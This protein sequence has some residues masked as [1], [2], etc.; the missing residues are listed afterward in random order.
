MGML[1]FLLAS[2]VVIG[3]APG[4][5]GMGVPTSCYGLHF[6]NPYYAV[7]VFFVISGFYMATVLSE[8]YH[9]ARNGTAL[10]Y[11][12]RLTRLLPAFWL[13][14]GATL[15]LICLFPENTF[16]PATF[17][18]GRVKPQ[19]PFAY[20]LS[21][22]QVALANLTI[23]GH[24]YSQFLDAFTTNRTFTN[25]NLIPQAWSIGTELSFY[26][27]APCL[28]QLRTRW[29]LV[30][31][32]GSLASRF[33]TIAAG[34]PFW[35]WQQRF[36]P[37]ELLFFLLG[38][39]AYRAYQ[40]Y[41]RLER[42]WMLNPWACLLASL[43]LFAAC[44]AIPFPDLATY[45]VPNATNSILIGLVVCAALPMVFHGTRSSRWDRA[46]GELSYPVYLWHICIGYYFSP[47]QVYGKGFCLLLCA[48]L[49]AIPTVLL[50]ERPVERWRQKLLR[51]SLTK[52]PSAAVPDNAKLEVLPGA[53]AA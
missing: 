40:T 21:I 5:G 35:P 22:V 44:C 39:L 28:V 33:I 17:V 15:I 36:F 4:W 48:V 50:V 46:I 47:A 45:G 31:G 26:L 2:A 7:Q 49:L 37:S 24:D 53:M 12:N 18:W 3:H 51:R 38:I 32:G 1:R 52:P 14:S 25:I 41:Q 20:H 27:L 13:V 23:I 6:L 9:R 34:L 11:I 16:P 29:L 42:P 43:P 10:F 30:L 19:F 8:K